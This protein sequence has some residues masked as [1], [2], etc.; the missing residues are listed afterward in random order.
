MDKNTRKDIL[1][2]IEELGIINISAS[3][4]LNTEMPS[5]AVDLTKEAYRTIDFKDISKR[6]DEDVMKYKKHKNAVVFYHT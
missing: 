1:E 2:N 3:E 4:Q 6:I 5:L